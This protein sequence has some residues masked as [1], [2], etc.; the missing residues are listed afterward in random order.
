MVKEDNDFKSAFVSIGILRE[1]E[2]TND[3]D[4]DLE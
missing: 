2:I 1:D 4:E 3:Y